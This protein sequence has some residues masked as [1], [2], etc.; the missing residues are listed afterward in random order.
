MASENK[1]LR[2]V[3][4]T[5]PDLKIEIPKKP[6][7]CIRLV[8]WNCRGKF[9]ERFEYVQSLD[10]D[11]YVISECTNP[12]NPKY[13]TKKFQDF[14]NFSKKHLWNES[15]R[16]YELSVGIFV[17]ENHNLEK[18]ENSYDDKNFISGNFSSNQCS[19]NIVGMWPSW[20]NDQKKGCCAQ[21][22][23]DYLNKHSEINS[24]YIIA[25]D[26]NIDKLYEN[27][28]SVC[29]SKTSEIIKYLNE[30]EKL[31]SA[32]HT[33]LNIINHDKKVMNDKKVMKTYYFQSK[34]N[35][36]S[37]VDYVFLN[38]EI[39]EIV[40][41]YLGVGEKEDWLKH[42]DHIPLIVDFKE[43]KQ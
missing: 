5:K 22:I 2:V 43:K 32:Y 41:V 17:K 31:F 7:D 13:S 30:D 36:T 28:S 12:Q 25:G 34:G 1:I 11:I 39:F 9:Y 42:S 40:K 38:Q 10:A 21:E 3:E 15:S 24:N 35:G 19:F 27:Q 20:S 4:I 8:T 23:L 37:H 18:N 6:R 16:K 14:Q 33:H 29:I 26:M